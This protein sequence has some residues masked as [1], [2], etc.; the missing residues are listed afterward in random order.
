[1]LNK[2]SLIT[3]LLLIATNSSATTYVYGNFA[4]IKSSNKSSEITS[5]VIKVDGELVKKLIS[6]SE[7][8]K[9]TVIY[10]G[11][12]VLA[13]LSSISEKSNNDNSK[14][15]AANCE[16]LVNRTDF[17]QLTKACGGDLMFSYRK[18]SDGY[19]F[20]ISN[21]NQELIQGTVLKNGQLNINKNLCSF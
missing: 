9:C 10:K 8:E 20:T 15:F 1:M 7:N 2:H 16:G 11:D 17:T 18:N 3:A 5:Q 19:L 12:P 14:I 6:I 21:S 13:T 4:E